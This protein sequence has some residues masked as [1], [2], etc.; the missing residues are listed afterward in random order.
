MLEAL[1]ATDRLTHSGWRDCK[2]VLGSVME[3]S[4]DETDA[5][6]VYIGPAGMSQ[7]AIDKARE[8]HRVL[9]G[10]DD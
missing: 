1:T 10:R 4:D 5:E 7:E 6:Q 2:R 3:D 8:W 9:M